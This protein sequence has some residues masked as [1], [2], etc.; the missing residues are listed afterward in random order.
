MCINYDLKE[1][2]VV[3]MEENKIVNGVNEVSIQMNEYKN[4]LF[5]NF[6]KISKYAFS[7]V[8]FFVFCRHKLR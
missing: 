1:N 2:E 4:N 5:I 6:Y 8:S 3:I 7:W